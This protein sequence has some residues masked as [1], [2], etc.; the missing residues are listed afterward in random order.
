MQAAA[1][2]NDE[3]ERLDA[4]AEL[5]LPDDLDDPQ[6]QGVA[7]IAARLCGAP[8][9]LI[10][11]VHADRQRALAGTGP[12]LLRETP[13][14]LSFCAHTILA[15]ALTEVRDAH[16]DVR[17]H[18]NPL[19]TGQ[20]GIRFYAGYPVVTADGFRLGTL[21]VVDRRPRNLGAAQRDAL[22]CLA[23]VVASLLDKRISDQR[24]RRSEAARRLGLHG[25]A[26]WAA[27]QEKAELQR[28]VMQM[29]RLEAAGTLAWGV[30]HDLNNLLLPIATMTD[31][32]LANLPEG[33]PEREYV[34]LIRSAGTRAGAMVRRLLTFA[35]DDPPQVEP[36]DLAAFVADALPL[37]RVGVRGDV[38][39][40]H[41]LQPVPT[42]R[43]DEA[44]LH[45]VLVNLVTNAI[46]A[47]AGKGGEVA[48]EV[49]PSP[50]DGDGAAPG[51]RLSVIDSGPGMDAE[52][53]RRAFEPFFTTKPVDRGTGLGLAV[54]QGI[55]AMHGGTIGLH[56]A[57]GL[58]TRIDIDFPAAPAAAPG[59]E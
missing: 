15:D 31:E 6:L 39:L 1:L 10:M 47:V 29:Q 9:A 24:L 32:L 52:T 36:L 11:I 22:K 25:A 34:Q 50:C 13:R 16:R 55:V 45:Q 27:E 8:T 33:M 53:R 42:V 44:Q 17:F 58:G 54:V 35:R 56:S 30:A 18:D 7:E 57:P 2:P 4:L 48:V 46:Q 43:A 23:G 40:R 19:V 38:S 28:Q 21:C 59:T 37:L 14:G 20:P 26:M 49:A 51:A 5:A 3:M 12:M 41:D